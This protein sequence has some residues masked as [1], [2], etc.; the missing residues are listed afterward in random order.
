M[1]KLIKTNKEKRA[2]S[3]GKRQAYKECGCYVPK[4]KKK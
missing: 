1:A 4:K 2:Y 3:I